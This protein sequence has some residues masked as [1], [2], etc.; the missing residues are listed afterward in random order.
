MITLTI[1]NPEVER[2]YK[3]D[4]NG[5][6]EKFSRFIS[7]ICITNNV[8]YSEDLSFLQEE[9]NSE[10]ANEDSG[11]THEELW[12]NLEKQYAN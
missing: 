8:E 5:D 7:E 10:D 4:F 12:D 11:Y 1:D 6:S 2:I 3:E 9:L